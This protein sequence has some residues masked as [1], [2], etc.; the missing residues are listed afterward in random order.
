MVIVRKSYFQIIG[1]GENEI[2]LTSD[3]C[4]FITYMKNILYLYDSELAPYYI[5]RFFNYNYEK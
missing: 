4:A 2:F 1:I 3:I 5:F